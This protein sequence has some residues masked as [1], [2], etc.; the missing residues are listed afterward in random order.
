MD[1]SDW[2]LIKKLEYYPEFLYQCVGVLVG[3]RKFID[4]EGASEWTSEDKIKIQKVVAK[5]FCNSA[6]SNSIVV[7]EDVPPT[8]KSSLENCLLLYKKDILKTLFIENVTQKTPL[9]T[10][11]D[12]KLKWVLGTS[13]LATIKEPILQLDFHCVSNLKTGPIQETINFEANLE[14]VDL[15]ITCL[16]TAK[17]QLEGDL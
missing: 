11:F 4:S 12:W 2:E 15:I 7:A 9:V 17:R 5:L 1:S 6:L 3:K 14:Q 13:K 10:N 8:L 16:T